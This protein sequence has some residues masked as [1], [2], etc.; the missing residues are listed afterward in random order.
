MLPSQ[1]VDVR[2]FNDRDGQSPYA[3]WF[4]SLNAQAA[5]KVATAMAR[6]AGGNFSNVKG[7]RSGVFEYRIDLAP[8]TGSISARMANT[9]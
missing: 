2:E 5:V 1:M 6:L 7:V 9:L 3:A 4:D 8:G